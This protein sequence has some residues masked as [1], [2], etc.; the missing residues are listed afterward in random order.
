MYL[1]AQLSLMR[2]KCKIVLFFNFAK[3]LFLAINHFLYFGA[4]EMGAKH[5]QI[6]WLA[7]VFVLVSANVVVQNFN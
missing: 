4:K 1:K 2:K 6:L 5:E 3:D 7:N